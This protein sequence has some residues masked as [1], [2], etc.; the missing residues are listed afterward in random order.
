MASILDQQHPGSSQV[1]GEIDVSREEEWA[2]SVHVRTL[3][4]EPIRR[5]LYHILNI[6]LDWILTQKTSGED[7]TKIK[8]VV[9]GRGL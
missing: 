8:S 2:P 6:D 1:I 4:T 5:D 7:H 3:E 9:Q